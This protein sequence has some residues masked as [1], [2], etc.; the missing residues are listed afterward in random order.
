MSVDIKKVAE[1][2]FNVVASNDEL[3]EG[4]LK[5]PIGTIKNNVKEAISEED[6][7][8]IAEEIKKKLDSGLDLGTGAAA[9]ALGN[10]NDALGN[11]FPGAGN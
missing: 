11:I 1:D 8:K 5:D 4:F 3:R 7:K 2:L 10:A 6:A 9:A